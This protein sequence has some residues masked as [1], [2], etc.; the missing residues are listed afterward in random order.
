MTQFMTLKEFLLLPE[1]SYDISR[2]RCGYNGSPENMVFWYQQ[3]KSS[4]LRF[5]QDGPPVGSPIV[6]IQPG[7]YIHNGF[8]TGIYSRDKRFFEM[9][10]RD[11]KSTPIYDIA[12]WWKHF[13]VD[14][15]P[16]V[17]L[18]RA[19][20]SASLDRIVSETGILSLAS[21]NVN[22]ISWSHCERLIQFLYIEELI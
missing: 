5:G 15:P 14:E 22:S 3:A 8:L 2:G 1:D 21:G 6:G 20:L 10:L 4:F 11:N 17:L 13:R 9:A 19:L 12:H 18:D 16:Q 7:K